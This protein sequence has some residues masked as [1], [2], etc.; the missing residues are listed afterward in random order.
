V[1]RAHRA[2]RT[3]PRAGLRRLV[4]RMGTRPAQPYRNNHIPRR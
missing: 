1:V 2:A 3:R 4:G